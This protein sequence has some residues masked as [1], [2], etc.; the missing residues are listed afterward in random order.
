MQATELIKKS[1]AYASLRRDLDGG[2]LAHAYM[3]VSEDRQSTDTLCDL[4]LAS[5]IYGADDD[6]TLERVRA[7]D[8]A[9]IQRFPKGDGGKVLVGDV[10]EIIDTVYFTPVELEKKFYIIDNFETANAASQNKLLKVLE[11][12]PKSVVFLLKCSKKEAVLPTVLSRVRQVE[13]APALDEQIAQYLIS[14][15]GES[16]KVYVATAMSG[17]FVGKAEELM[18]D[19]K[20]I[21]MFSS[22][23]ETLK[24]MKTSK[25]LLTYSARLI[26]YKDK[27][28]RLIQTF[29]LIL[30]DC[31]RAS[32]GVR[33]ELRFKGNVREITELSREYTAEVV[34]KL[35]SAIVRAQQ[36]LELN[37]NAQSVLD[38]F[39]FSLLE[40]KAK[41]RKS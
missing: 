39:L 13:I 36:R 18:T 15:Y 28:T 10:E 12:P 38:E 33:A 29:E 3:I 37:G 2:R 21:D 26:A 9:D 17:G 11:E 24:G 35:R 27:L 4:L 22:A 25:Q 31:M 8:K 19:K 1:R 20:E 41:C 5:F 30:C 6:A 23:I 7:V 40:V 14:R 32:S 16:P 34:I